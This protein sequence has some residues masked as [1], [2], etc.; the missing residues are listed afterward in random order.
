MATYKAD[1]LIGYCVCSVS[2]R[3]AH[4]ISIAVQSNYRRKGVAT[5]LL[6]RLVEHL[7]DM[8]VE[9][10]WLEVSVNNQEAVA[11]YSKRS[12][13]KQTNLPNYYS[14]GSNA[15]RM[16]LV[17]SKGTSKPARNPK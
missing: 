14:D 1:E 13:E 8:S 16:S 15:F 2:G 12:F 3:A 10:M 7:K 6:D 4:L 11:L 9:E 5:S 17:L